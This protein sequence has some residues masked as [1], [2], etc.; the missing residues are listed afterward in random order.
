MTPVSGASHALEAAA[1]K[2]HIACQTG[3]TLLRS[4]ELPVI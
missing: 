2:A 3:A 4:I 1:R